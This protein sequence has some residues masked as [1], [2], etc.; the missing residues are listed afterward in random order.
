MALRVVEK[1]AAV[2]ENTRI[3]T[4]R[5]SKRD[6][7]QPD[8]RYIRISGIFRLKPPDLAKRQFLGI[9]QHLFVTLNYPDTTK[10]LL[11]V[12]ADLPNIPGHGGPATWAHPISCSV[13]NRGIWYFLPKCV[14]EITGGDYTDIVKTTSIVS[15]VS[16]IGGGH[17]HILSL[18]LLT[19]EYLRLRYKD[20]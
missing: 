13:Y 7:G 14:W 18:P 3:Y 10:D 16:G 11:S 1:Q 2:F 4:H 5:R 8:G 6:G 17:Y 19:R 20:I 12:A 15:V 9:H